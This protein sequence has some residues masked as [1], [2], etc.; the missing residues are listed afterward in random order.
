[1]VRK[2]FVAAIRIK[3][4][5]VWQLFLQRV[6]KASTSLQNPSS[7][8]DGFSMGCAWR[9]GVEMW[10]CPSTP[11]A[12]LKNELRKQCSGEGRWVGVNQPPQKAGRGSDGFP[13][14]AGR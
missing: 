10:I 11:L 1:M 3:P 8:L 13:G 4:V 12:G 2:S 7:L 9:E 14:V 5:S 6:V